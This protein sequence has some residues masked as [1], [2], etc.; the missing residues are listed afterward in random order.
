MAVASV[1]DVQKESRSLQAADR[2]YRREVPK[3][4]ISNKGVGKPKKFR[5]GSQS[6]ETAPLSEVITSRRYRDHFD[7]ITHQEGPGEDRAT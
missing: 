2:Q 3:G 5:A 7:K 1:G 6:Q 4:T